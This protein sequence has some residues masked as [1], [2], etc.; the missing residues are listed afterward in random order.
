MTQ[1]IVILEQLAALEHDQWVAWSQQIAKTEKISP[2]RLARW[3]S[4]WIPYAQLTEEQKDSD[5]DWARK[6]YNIVTD[7]HAS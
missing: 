4:L 3:E 5:R 7:G 1:P 2:E 6:A